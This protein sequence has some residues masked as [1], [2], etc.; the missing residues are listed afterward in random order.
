MIEFPYDVQTCGF[1]FGSWTYTD[2][3]LCLIPDTH[4]SLMEHF[5][6]STEFD[7]FSSNYTLGSKKYQSGTYQNISYKLSFKRKSA[8]YV[9]VSKNKILR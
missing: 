7:V 1:S 6:N 3:K 5:K 4:A 8:F 9:Q 2:D